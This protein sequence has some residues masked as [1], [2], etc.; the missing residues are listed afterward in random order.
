MSNFQ[1]IN[2]KPFLK[3]LVNKT[4]IVRL[5]WNKM[6][7]KGRLVS[8]DNYMNLQLDQTY[9]IT[10]ESEDGSDDKKEELIGEI[11]I[12]CNNVLFIREVVDGETTTE[13]SSTL[14]EEEKVTNGSKEVEVEVTEE[15]KEVEMEE[16]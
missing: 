14:K 4:I 16:N 10:K 11:F 9:E 12:R 8:I 7:Y 6:E 1:P 13:E 5:K 15:V 3:S 2:P